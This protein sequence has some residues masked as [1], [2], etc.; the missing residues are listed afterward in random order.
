MDLTPDDFIS[1]T[2]KCTAVLKVNTSTPHTV[3]QEKDV[4][5]PWNPNTHMNYQNPNPN[6]VTIV[7]KAT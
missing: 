2:T 5:P 7:A 3:L 1:Q 4:E 6:M